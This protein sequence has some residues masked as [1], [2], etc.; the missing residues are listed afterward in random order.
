M[1]LLDAGF[2]R[3]NGSYNHEK[4]LE[5]GPTIQVGVSI[6]TEAKTPFLTIINTLALIDT[7]AQSSMIDENLAARLELNAIDKA[8]VSGIS[9]R[10]TRA[11]FM[12]SIHASQLGIN[13]AGRLLSARLKDGGQNHEILLGR[14]F[15]QNVMLIYDGPRGQ[16]TIACAKN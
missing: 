8:M 15:L 13:Q 3:P 5:S 11:V 12:A 6:Y 7:G 2:I 1:P 9:G 10:D 4:L 16:V 14:D